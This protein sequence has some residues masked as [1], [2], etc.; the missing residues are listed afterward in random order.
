M[1]KIISFIPSADD[2]RNTNER[3]TS[4]ERRYGGGELEEYRNWLKYAICSGK[5]SERNQKYAGGP[6]EACRRTSGST[7]EDQRQPI[8]Y[9]KYGHF[10]GGGILHS[11]IH[12]QYSAMHPAHPRHSPA[13][14][15]EP[16]GKWPEGDGRWRALGVSTAA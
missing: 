10:G 4:E 3:T 16:L 6:A 11:V 9:L 5:A 2:W 8:F 7:P 1:K 15:P 13:T 14:P 12:R